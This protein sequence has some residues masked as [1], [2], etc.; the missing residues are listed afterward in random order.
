MKLQKEQQQI[1]DTINKD[2]IISAGAGSGKT[3]VMIEKILSNILNNHISV[4]QL[5][6]VTFTNAAATEMRQKLENRL[7][8]HLSTLDSESD[9][10]KFI[11]EQINLLP[12][13]NICTLHKFC[14]NII[15]KYFYALDIETGFSILEDTDAKLL[16]NRA[17]EDVLQNLERT[18]EKPVIDLLYIYDVKRDN[19]KIKEIVFKVYDYLENQPDVQKFCK[20]VLDA[21]LTPLDENVFCNIINDYLTQRCEYYAGVF[22][23]FV[24]SANMADFPKLAECATQCKNVALLLNKNNTFTQNLHILFSKLTDLPTTPK[25]KGDNEEL[26]EE[27]RLARAE[28]SDELSSFKKMCVA[29]D[30]N[31]LYA[32]LVHNRDMMQGIFT[33]SQRFKQRFDTLKRKRNVVDFGDLEHLCLNILSN[34]DIVQEV[35]QG[36]KA[37]YVDEYQDINDIQ[38]NIISLVHTDGNLFL[39][40][41]VKQSIYGFR[42]TNPQIFLNKV[43]DFSLEPNLKAYIRLNCNFRSDQ[44]ILDFVNLVFAKLMTDGS[45][46]INYASTS[47]MGSDQQYDV[48]DTT[49]SQVELDVVNTH[50]EDKPEK[51]KVSKVYSVRDAEVVSTAELDVAK[52]EADVIA[53]KINLLFSQQKQIFDPKLG[54]GGGLRDIKFADISIL[55]QSRSASMSVILERL[56]ERG[57]PVEDFGGEDLFSSYEIQ[58][59][60][61]YLKLLNNSSDD[62]ALATLLSSPVVNLSEE[63][64]LDIRQSCTDKKFYYECLSSVTDEKILEK[65]NKL[66]NLLNLGRRTLCNGTVYDCLNAFVQA[67]N[68]QSIV[69]LLPM[70]KSRVDNINVFIN[71]FVGK[72]YNTSL[73]EFVNFVETNNGQLELNKENNSGADVVHVL[74]MHHS[75]GLEYPI[76]FLANL[77]H[78]FNT[79]SQRDEV[80]FFDNLGVGLYAYDYEKRIKRNTLARSAIVF[81]LKERALAENLRLLY[82]AMT[83]A[84]NNLYCVGSIDTVDFVPA[85]ST[86]D[87]RKCDSFLSLMLSGVREV[88]SDLAHTSHIS[89]TALDYRKN[90]KKHIFDLNV[91]PTVV[92]E[93][94][95]SEILTNPI[96]LGDYV[97]EFEQ[98]VYDMSNFSYEF[99]QSTQI[100]L[101]NSVTALNKQ[102][103]Q[104]VMVNTNDEATSFRLDEARVATSATLGTTYHKAM[105]L[106]DFNLDTEQQ[107]YQ[108]L[109]DKMDIDELNSIDCGKILAC[110]RS[111]RPLVNQADEVLREQDFM[112]YVPYNAVVQ[113]NTT[114][115]VLVQGIIDLVLIKGNEATLIDYKLTN[116]R[117]PK[118]L[119]QKYALQLKCYTM[120]IQNSKGVTV[121]KKILYSFL[122]EMQIIV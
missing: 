55:C 101:K 65:L 73:F 60:Y 103:E 36:F 117:D 63:E 12:Q 2:I 4:T 102:E 69:S 41:D 43:Q 93:T 108:F 120:A 9:E 88:V 25:A 85:I 76:V 32:D 46:G 78:S 61:N 115:K 83:R 15:S 31:L 94:K 79:M 98:L 33:L 22:E 42:N 48:P 72:S 8:S 109:S 58:L 74:T 92:H 56:R 30:P 47:L 89:V 38:E 97:P 107:I 54:D 5:L 21:Y 90:I 6:V 67:T 37:V 119:A 57:I 66:D 121:T 18:E 59:L 111:L 113:S 105:Q 116:I 20:N 45:A 27:F 81:K 77:G 40:G 104:D 71:H 7:R 34:Q 26:K 29:D 100:G 91:Y 11:L 96:K 28:F 24:V 1:L 84:K 86:F 114:D 112:L 82:V 39:V 99:A 52:T 44:R 110:L 87:L 70:G 19:R 17:I 3:F 64:M 35:R 106:I 50:Q 122:Q 10:Y 75:K 14:Q 23:T 53:D 118:K 68:L 62:L 80:V 49:I 16:R 95:N 13:S 51:P